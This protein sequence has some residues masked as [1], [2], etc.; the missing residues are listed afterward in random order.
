MSGEKINFEQFK[1]MFF[2]NSNNNLNNNL[3]YF[4]SILFYIYI[5][6]F[7][8]ILIKDFKFLYWFY[9]DGD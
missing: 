4:L 8:F 2:Q 5:N 7:D 9:K 6:R 1:S 3:K